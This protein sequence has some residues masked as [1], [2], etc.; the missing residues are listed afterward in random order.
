[1]HLHGIAGWVREARIQGSIAAIV[2]VYLQPEVVAHRAKDAQ[3]AIVA[4][5]PRGKDGERRDGGEHTVS[6]PCAV[7]RATPATEPG[8]TETAV[9]RAPK[10]LRAR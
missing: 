8:S 1:M 10:G 5:C 3:D 9:W 7:L 2:V 4:H 6:Q